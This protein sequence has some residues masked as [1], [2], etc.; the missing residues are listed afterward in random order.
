[1]KSF[2]KRF[3]EVIQSF[4]VRQLKFPTSFEQN[5]IANHQDFLTRYTTFRAAMRGSHDTTSFRIRR[6]EQSIDE[7]HCCYTTVACMFASLF[8]WQQIKVHE[9]NSSLDLADGKNAWNVY[10]D[11][12][13]STCLPQPLL[14]TFPFHIHPAIGCSRKMVDPMHLAGPFALLLPFVH[15]VLNTSLR[16]GKVVEFLKKCMAFVLFVC[17]FFNKLVDWKDLAGTAPF[18][19]WC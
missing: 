7:R 4:C 5:S 11:Y 14:C 8:H 13:T 9:K 6:W 15:A 18:Q 2:L 10:V 17:S 12:R 19:T 1:M 16:N 3:K